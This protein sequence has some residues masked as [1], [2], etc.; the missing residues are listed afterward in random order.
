MAPKVSSKVA[1]E[2]FDLDDSDGEANEGQ[3]Q[4]ASHSEV[5]GLASGAPELVAGAAEGAAAPHTTPG[6]GEA[7]REGLGG[8]C[9]PGG[10]EG[11]PVRRHQGPPPRAH[12]PAGGGEER[13]AASAAAAEAVLRGKVA[14]LLAAYRRGCDAAGLSGG[15]AERTPSTGGPHGAAPGWAAGLA[16]DPGGEGPH[17]A[18]VEPVPGEPPGPRA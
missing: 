6:E 13:A 14:S 15:A 11:P 12:S 3:E 4:L 9:G 16:S 5:Q 1:V 8:A 2:V 17:E 7:D 18:S 10:V